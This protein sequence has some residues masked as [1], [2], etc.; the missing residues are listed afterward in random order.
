MEDPQRPGR[1]IRVCAR[2]AHERPFNGRRVLALLR[3]GCDGLS[4]AETGRPVCVRGGDPAGR[5]PDCGA[6]AAAHYES[7]RLLVCGHWSGPASCH[8]YP[9]REWRQPRE[10]DI[11]FGTPNPDRAVVHGLYCEIDR[12]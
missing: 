9:V 3:P 8:A 2:Q 1:R 12:R 6:L 5:T 7:D 4:D 11:T 10:D